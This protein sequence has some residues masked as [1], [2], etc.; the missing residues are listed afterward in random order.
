[1]KTY[2]TKLE[3]GKSATGYLTFV[4][5]LEKESEKIQLGILGD[6]SLFKAGE[7]DSFYANLTEFGEP[8]KIKIC[9]DK[10]VSNKIWHVE[11][12]N[13]IIYTIRDL[14]NY[15]LVIYCERY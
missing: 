10:T 2:T 8:T 11:K 6:D 4:N 1:M 12:V 5:I 14:A 9:L 3:N 7:T 13:I 15:T